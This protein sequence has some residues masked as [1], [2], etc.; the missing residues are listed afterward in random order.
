MSK[1]CLLMRSCSLRNDSNRIGATG[2]YAPFGYLFEI[3]RGNRRHSCCF[4]STS[5]V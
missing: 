2:E 5:T 3:S 4:R 1:Q